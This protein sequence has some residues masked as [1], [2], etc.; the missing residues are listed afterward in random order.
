MIRKLLLI[1]FA[2]VLI[3]CSSDEGTTK[4]SDILL[5]TWE[6]VETRLNDNPIEEDLILNFRNDGTVVYTYK[7]YFESGDD[8]TERGEWTIEDDVLTILFSDSDGDV[9][10]LNDILK[11]SV[12]ELILR[13]DLGAEGTLVE[14]FMKR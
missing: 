4:S 6:K 8:L 13:T 7:G 11:L 1:L 3:A 5:G 2:A 10:V 14:T 12:T 9:L